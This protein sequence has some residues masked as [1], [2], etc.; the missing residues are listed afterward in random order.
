MLILQL[1]LV[2]QVR[3]D[4]PNMQIP[5]GDGALALHV[6]PRYMLHNNLR[7]G[8]QYKQQVRPLNIM[9]I[10]ARDLPHLAAYTQSNKA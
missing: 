2:L 3:C 5:D 9:C 7:A 1:M 4:V 6:M 10:S 8:V